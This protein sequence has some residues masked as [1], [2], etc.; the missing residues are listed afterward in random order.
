VFKT[1]YIAPE[2]PP[3]PD[4]PDLDCSGSLTWN[5]IEPGATVVGSFQVKNK[6]DSGSQLNWT[7]DSSSIVWGAWSFT[8]TSGNELTPEDG[9][10]T[11]EVSVVA[12]NQKNIE[13]QGNLRIE[14][15]D[16]S[17]D[18]CLIPV[19]LKTPLN[20]NLYLKN[21]F[22]SMLQGFP[23]KLTILQQWFSYS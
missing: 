19:Y 12:P 13:F 15:Q 6:G 17:T 10:V 14:N 20:Q 9:Q 8:P 4:T 5:N 23:F 7:I 2:E 11:V 18:F 22:E 21:L 3:E 1:D 16:N